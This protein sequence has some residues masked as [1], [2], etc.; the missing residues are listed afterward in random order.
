MG[1]GLWFES[2]RVMLFQRASRT[3]FLHPWSLW[4]DLLFKFRHWKSFGNVAETFLVSKADWATKSA[5]RGA[6]PE[7]NS[8]F[9]TDLGVAF[10]H[11]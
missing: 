4:Y 10:E 6:P 8:F 7:I 11:Y 2:V 3:G 5:P 9:G 1:L